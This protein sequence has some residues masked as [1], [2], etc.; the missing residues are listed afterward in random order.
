MKRYAFLLCLLAVF[1]R[2]VYYILPEEKREVPVIV[3]T[4]Y[5]NIESALEFMK[6]G[7]YNYLT[8]PI[9]FDELLL[10]IEKAGEK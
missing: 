1:T 10:R 9:N 6:K 3:T 2:E 4:T 5:G 7:A 8:K